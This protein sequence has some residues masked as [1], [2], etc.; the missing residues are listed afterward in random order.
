M[1][2][3][4]SIVVTGPGGVLDER[5]YDYNAVGNRAW[6]V[7]GELAPQ[8]G[9]PVGEVYEYDAIDQVTGVKYGAENPNL[10]YSQASAPA[11]VEAFSS[12]P[13]GNRAS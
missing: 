2:R 5:H 10:G 9:D 12:D 13:A 4:T 11:K 7:Q 1:N 6:T 8:N 3:V